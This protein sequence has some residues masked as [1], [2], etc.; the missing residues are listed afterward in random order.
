MI[1]AMTF[2]HPHPNK[3]EAIS[4]PESRFPMVARILNASHVKMEVRIKTQFLSSEVTYAAYLVYKHETSSDNTAI[5][6]LKYKLDNQSHSYISYHGECKDGW[7]MMEL[8]QTNSHR[9]NVEFN[10][11][12]EKFD[13]ISKKQ[14]IV[15]GI[16]F[17]PIQK[18]DDEIKT[19]V[20]ESTPTTDIEWENRLPSD[21]EKFLKRPWNFFI[22]KTK[23][24]AYSIL[25]QGVYIT[26]KD[27]IHMVS[28]LGS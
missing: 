7:V 25:S 20:V 21:Y 2:M 24:E 22:T 10:V 17:L 15:E 13:V 26:I 9:R 19:N 8:F 23:E 5:I 28:L 27:D 18:L 1:S 11:F 6:S 16:I 3:C 14:V 12:L 4:L